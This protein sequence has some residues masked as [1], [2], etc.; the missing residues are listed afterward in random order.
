[1]LLKELRRKLPHYE[2]EPD[3]T[4]SVKKNLKLLFTHYALLGGDKFNTEYL[5]SA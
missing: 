4:E 2:S 3:I 5:K 1:M